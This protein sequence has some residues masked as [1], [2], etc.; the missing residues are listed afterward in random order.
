MEFAV[1][2][3]IGVGCISILISIPGIIWGIYD[4]KRR[5]RQEQEEAPPSAVTQ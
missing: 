1:Y 2:I 5:E 3:S 4:N